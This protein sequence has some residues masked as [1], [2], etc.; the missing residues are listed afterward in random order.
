MK[1][2]GRLVGGGGGGEEGLTPWEDLRCSAGLRL[3]ARY[4]IVYIITYV[5]CGPDQTRVC[6]LARQNTP[7]V[8]PQWHVKDP[9]QVACYSKDAGSM[10]QLN[11]TA[12]SVCGCE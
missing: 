5:R 12:V 11:K 6:R 9:G 7:L 4:C 8:L 1:R 3:G 10:L 2:D